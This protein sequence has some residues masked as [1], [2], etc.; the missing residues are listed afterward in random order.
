MIA[1][2]LQYVVESSDSSGPGP[3]TPA[4]LASATRPHTYAPLG[5]SVQPLLPSLIEPPLGPRNTSAVPW[6]RRRQ[7]Q[8]A[9]GTAEPMTTPIRDAAPVH[10]WAMLKP[11]V[12]GMSGPVLGGAARVWGGRI[13]L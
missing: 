4:R 9:P 3:M 13:R 10:A 6:F 7:R 5:G 2:A 12:K 1:S 8:S 11:M